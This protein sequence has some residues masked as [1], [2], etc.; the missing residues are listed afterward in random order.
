MSFLIGSS[1]MV[2]SGIS[3]ILRDGCVGEVEVV[4]SISSTWQL[5]GD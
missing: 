3:S 4:E 1:V 5:V 2:G